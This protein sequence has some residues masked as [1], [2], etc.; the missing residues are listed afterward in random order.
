M[1]RDVSLRMAL[2]IAETA[3]AQCG[4]KT[5]NSEN[6]VYQDLCELEGEKDCC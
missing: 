2:T 5:S 3:L 6:P 4:V 1:E